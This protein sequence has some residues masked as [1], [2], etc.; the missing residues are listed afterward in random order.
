MPLRI[1]IKGGFRPRTRL[2]ARQNT[3]KYYA[4]LHASILA[5]L[6]VLCGGRSAGYTFMAQYRAG[7]GF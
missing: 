2:D 5:T 3:G 6:C 7:K 4:L 1:P